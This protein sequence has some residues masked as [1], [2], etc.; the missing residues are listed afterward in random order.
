MLNLRRYATVRINM[1][2][3]VF[4]GRHTDDKL[5]RL[6]KYLSAWALVM[7][8]QRFVKVYIDAFA[9]SGDRTIV[10]DATPLFGSEH[11]ADLTVPGSARRALGID[12]PFDVFVLIEKDPGRFQSLQR[13]EDEHRDRKFLLRQGDANEV[14]LRL[15]RRELWQN[16]PGLPQG[17]RGVLFLDP[18]GMEVRWST[19][20]AIAET[21]AIDVWIFFPLMGLY[22]QAPKS[23]P[24]A[25]DDP[26]HHV[27]TAVLGT[28][29]WR[30]AWYP[31]PEI[32]TDLFD[33]DGL[34]AVQRKDVD[35]LESYVHERLRTIFKGTVL[36]ARRI[37][38]QRGAPLASLFFAVSNPAEVAVKAASRIASH[39]LK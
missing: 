26:K 25:L 16:T 9:G 15:C 20:A 22:R 12:P 35:Q 6:E 28:D 34:E 33:N 38:N 32:R 23:A 39:I 7:K 11:G 27:L 37:K 1:T 29:E 13:L 21:Q 2:G 4:G 24:P 18:Y 30:N 31:E 17:M 10:R 8:N 3:H 19:L 5:D 14:L 36:P